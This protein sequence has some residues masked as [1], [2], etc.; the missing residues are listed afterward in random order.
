MTI[1][2]PPL[3]K[4][5]ARITRTFS[6]SPMTLRIIEDEAELR[7][8]SVGRVIDALADLLQHQHVKKLMQ[9][10]P[11]FMSQVADLQKKK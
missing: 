4:D 1:G 7:G 10:D 6:V 9:A 2:R 11:V 3:P 8:V 5:R